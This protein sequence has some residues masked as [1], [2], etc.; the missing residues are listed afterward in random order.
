MKQL[1]LLFLAFF[2]MSVCAADAAEKVRVSDQDLKRMSVFLS[3]FTELGLTDIPDVS[4]LTAGKLVYFGIWHNYINNYSRIKNTNDARVSIDAKFV[5]DSIKKY[6]AI[7]IKKSDLKSVTH[8][9]QN[10]I[11]DGKKYIFEGANL[12][13][14]IYAQVNE[15]YRSGKNLLM[16]GDIYKD[17][18]VKEV[19]GKFTAY[20]KPWKYGGKETWALLS[21]KTND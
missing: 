13:T 14:A 17:D 3:N 5:L 19:L 21:I 7:D 15:V 10:F 6:F 1:L 9:Q 16:K 18:G 8:F 4:K 12:D 11:Y 20:A 2:L